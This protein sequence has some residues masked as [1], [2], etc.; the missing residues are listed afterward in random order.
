MN[1]QARKI[2]EADHLIDGPEAAHPKPDNGTAEGRE[3][4]D[5]A[6]REAM[7]LRTYSQPTTA[8]SLQLQSHAPVPDQNG[9]FTRPASSTQTRRSGYGRGLER[10]W[11]RQIA[12]TVPHIAC[13]D[14]L[15]K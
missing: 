2:T 1:I 14:H 9:D 6:E 7:E 3:E 13:R 8:D 4:N 10:F 12:M 5:P 15:G 11:N